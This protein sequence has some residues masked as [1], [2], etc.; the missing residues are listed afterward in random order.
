MLASLAKRILCILV[1]SAK[2][3]RV[4]ST[5]GNIVTAKRNRIAPKNVESLIVIK[6][7]MALFE[8]FLKN[9]GYEIEKSEITATHLKK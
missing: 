6:K 2:S 9:S 1:S 4:F 3:E 8:D 5:G 7:N